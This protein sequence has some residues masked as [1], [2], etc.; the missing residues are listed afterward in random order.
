MP[1]MNSS[2]LRW[3]A[4]TAIAVAGVAALG[5]SAPAAFAASTVDNSNNTTTPIKH[6]VVIF[7]ENVSFD[8]YFG[9]Y[10]N[11]SNADGT[12]FTPAAGTP[13]P[14]NYT[15][16]PTLLTAN[17]N[18]F[19]PKRLA[20]SQALTCSQNHAY[21]PE[22]LAVNGG[23]MD[24]FV[25]NTQSKGC[26][27][28]SLYNGDGAVMGYYDGNT[29]TGLWNYAQNYA[30]SDN[31]WDS[32]FGPSTPGALNLISGQ[33]HGGLGV[34]S[35]TGAP[36]TAGAGV[37]APDANG[38]GTVIADP[39]PYYDDCSDTN[40]TATSPLVQMQG[41]NIGDLLNARG[42]SWGWFQGGF[43]P[44][45][46]WDGTDGHYAVCGATMANLGGDTPTSYSPHHSP[47]EYYAST[48]NPHHLPPTSVGAIGHDDQANHNYD[49][50]DFDAALGKGNLPAV[51]FLKA[52]AAQDGHPANSDPIDEQNFLIKEI[53]AIEKSP[54][55][56]STAVIVNYDD[57]DGWYDHVAPTILNGSKDAANDGTICA[58]SSA[59]TLGGYADRCG[60]SQRIPLVVISPFAKQNYIDHTA[61]TQA[62]VLKFVENN[63]SAGRVGDASFDA[64]A[65]DITPMFDFAAPQ[66]RSVLLAAN[67][68][69]SAITPISV[70]TGNV[71]TTTPAAVPDPELAATGARIAWWSVAGAALLV[72]AGL[73]LVLARRRTRTR[74]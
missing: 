39:D 21:K 35:K 14:N 45:T 60:P 71:N 24:K 30:I 13:V 52:P 74:G 38:V 19:A 41:K 1:R 65:G 27:P 55:W 29:V 9:S 62:S 5:V 3:A 31:S 23:A 36:I 70:P 18:A 8:H 54:E 11:A 22:Q 63:W 69:V 10:P 17:P 37:V 4:A 7:D 32:T 44:T 43:A 48:S 26:K 73:V 34:D 25:E 59:P 42:V 67:G 16:T 57:S 15:K 20:P 68:S 47:F 28:S 46:P 12:P 56:K 2:R 61:T 64:G 6:V 58:S 53:N 66:Q 49:I 72:V 51:S 40:H 33:T 50:T